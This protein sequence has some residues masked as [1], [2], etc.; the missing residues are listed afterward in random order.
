VP[1]GQNK[2]SR[3]RFEWGYLLVTKPMDWARASGEREVLT[4]TRFSIQSRGC[5]LGLV[6]A[7]LTMVSPYRYGIVCGD[8]MSPAF[9]NGNWYV[10]DQGYYRHHTPKRGDVVVFQ[11][12]GATYVKRVAAVGG[13]T[14]YLLRQS[15]TGDVDIIPDWQIDRVR[16]YV[17]VRPWKN[18]LYLMEVKVSPGACFVLGDNLSCSLDSRNFGEIPVTAIKG[19]VCDAPPVSGRGAHVA[20]VFQAAPDQS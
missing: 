13:D 10:L 12:S 18:V 1:P 19:R 9:H 8:S 14:V 2:Y 20:G 11:K 7:G 6:L 15:G 16:R 5:Y 4:L 17:H 3:L